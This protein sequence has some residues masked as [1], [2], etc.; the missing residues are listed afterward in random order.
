VSY[1]NDPVR[2]ARAHRQRAWWAFR[3]KVGLLDDTLLAELLGVS[4]R[5]IQ[6]YET[7]ARP[8]AWYQAALL[9][10]VETFPDRV[11]ARRGKPRKPKLNRWGNDVTPEPSNP[12]YATRWTTGGKLL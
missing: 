8:P 3:R 1:R 4:T 7:A 11:F 10:L 2:Q 9:G 6:R 5:S 12:Y